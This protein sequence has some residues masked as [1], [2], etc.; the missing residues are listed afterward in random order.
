MFQK[1]FSE[2][3]HFLE[4]KV[5]KSLKTFKLKYSADHQ[6]VTIILKKRNDLNN[7]PV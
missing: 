5:P 2:L 7:F 3:L 4:E 6:I 1:D